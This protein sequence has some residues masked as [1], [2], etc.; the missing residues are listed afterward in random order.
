[1]SGLT[2][3]VAPNSLV[4]ARALRESMGADIATGCT[5]AKTGA[6]PARQPPFILKLDVE[7][8][9]PLESVPCDMAAMAGPAFATDGIGIAWAVVPRTKARATSNL[10]RRWSKEVRTR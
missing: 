9:H 8:L 7:P 6:Q 1:M 3:T 2:A 10:A 5:N 4:Q